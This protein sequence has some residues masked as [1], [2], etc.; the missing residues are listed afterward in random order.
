MKLIR[1]F[2]FFVFAVVRFSTPLN[3][4]RNTGFTKYVSKMSHEI[5]TLAIADSVCKIV[6]D[7]YCHWLCT[8]IFTAVYNELKLKYG[9]DA[10]IDRYCSELTIN[11]FKCV[12]MN[13]VESLCGQEQLHETWS[14]SDH[15]VQIALL[16]AS[17]TTFKKSVSC[18]CIQSL[19]HLIDQESTLYDHSGNF[20]NCF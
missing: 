7:R 10:E 14:R 16:R 17:S 4:E 8:V 20:L 1:F 11:I 13:A 12:Y 3:I 9:T 5:C 15:N 6:L 18:E 19:A 2:F